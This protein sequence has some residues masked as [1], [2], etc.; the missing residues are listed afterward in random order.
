MR[1]TV[2]IATYNGEKYIKEQLDSILL[3]IGKDDEVIISDDY[4]TDRT[5]DIIKEYNDPR[6]KIYFNNNERGYTK[7]F[8]NALKKSSGEIIFLSD[9]DDIWLTNKVSLVKEKLK[10]AD[11]VVTD[12]IVVNDKKEIITKSMFSVLN[13]QTGFLKNIIKNRY[14]GCCIA[15][16]RQ[17]L[18]RLLPF[19][20]NQNLAPHDIWIP[21]ISEMYYKVALVKEPCLLYRRHDNNTSNFGKSSNSIWKKLLLRIYPI[22]NALGRKYL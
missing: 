21:I 16:N 13:T 11:M 22:Y 9:Q 19:P 12:A 2:C 3:Q 1:I 17:I 14:Q 6:I 4:S 20:K 18:D 7:N 8:E 5:L 10:E 15:F